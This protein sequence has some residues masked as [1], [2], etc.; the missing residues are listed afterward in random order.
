MTALFLPDEDDATVAPTRSSFDILDA[1]ERTES[2]ARGGSR[3]LP[4]A[5]ARGEGLWLDDLDGRRFMDV[6]CA[7]GSLALGHNHPVVVAALQR[8]IAEGLPLSGPDDASPVRDAFVSSV[9]ATLPTPFG[10]DARLHFCSPSGADAVEAALKLAR[11]ATGR[12]AIVAFAGASHGHTQGAGATTGLRLGRQVPGA[13]GADVHFLP[14]SSCYRCP[15]GQDGCRSRI[16]A[17]ELPPCGHFARHVMEDPDNGI[18]PVAGFLVEPV[19]GVGGVVP[20]DDVWLRHLGALAHAEGSALIVDETQTGWGRTGSLY[21]FDESGVSPDVVVLPRAIGGG[22]PLAAIVLR[23]ELD[24]W[25]VGSHAG[26]F[27]ANLLAMT[28]G[29]ATL[30]HI[31][32]GDLPR[33]ATAMGARLMAQLGDL[34]FVHGCV[35][36]VRGRGLMFGIEF[37]DERAQDAY[38]RPAPSGALARAVQAAC[39]RRGLLVDVGGRYGAVVRL[40]PPLIVQADDI[41]RIAATLRAACEDAVLRDA[42]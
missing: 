14:Y 26:T 42:A 1:I 3:R 29:L 31:E 33:R 6:A 25:P 8:H 30:R 19:Q 10:D 11:A 16:A 40:M 12:S 13:V 37:V 41:D 32:D 38:G 27:R 28:A 21:A 35:G 24:L 20:A 22:L 7:G 39:F 23:S 18:P 17:A 36:D 15:V 4:I 9:L 34:P 2:V 5:V